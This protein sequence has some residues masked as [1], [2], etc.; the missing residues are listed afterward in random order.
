MRKKTEMNILGN[1]IETI[2][3]LYSVWRCDVGWSG[4][5]IPFFYHFYNWLKRSLSMENTKKAE[6]FSSE[7]Y[8]FSRDFFW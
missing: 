8:M 3:K 5:F 7:S 1:Y 4:S 2:F 6:N